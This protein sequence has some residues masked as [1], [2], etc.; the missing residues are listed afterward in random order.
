MSPRRRAARTIG[1]RS[2]RLH[3]KSTSDSAARRVNTNAALTSE[4]A[5]STAK[6]ISPSTA[7]YSSTIAIIDS[8]S[9]AWWKATARAWARR[10][11]TSRSPLVKAATMASSSAVQHTSLPPSVE[12]AT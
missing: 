2:R 10:S 9:R 5:P 8:N 4:T 6:A 3:A 1:N 11:A 7:A 12:V